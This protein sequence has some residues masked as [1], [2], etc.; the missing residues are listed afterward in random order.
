M[1]NC[2]N[3]PVLPLVDPHLLHTHIP[4][5]LA[6]RSVTR[7]SSRLERFIESLVEEILCPVGGLISG[8]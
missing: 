6:G 4:L 1:E 8:L 7:R 3:L 5:S 2:S